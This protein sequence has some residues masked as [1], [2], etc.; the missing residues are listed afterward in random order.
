CAEKFLLLL[1][2]GFDRKSGLPL[3][4]EN[5]TNR[6]ILSRWISLPLL[7]LFVISGRCAN[8]DPVGDLF[9]KVG[10]SVSKAFQ[11]RPT[12]IPTTE[13]KTTKRAPRRTNARNITATVASP[14]PLEKPTDLVKE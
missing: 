2:R 14:T 8:A 10:Q 9:K 5:S 13:K 1:D 3:K 11:P 12:P 7:A 6:F 4:L